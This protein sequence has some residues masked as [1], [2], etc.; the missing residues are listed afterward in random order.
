MLENALDVTG[1]E[2][3]TEDEESLLQGRVPESLK[4][5][6]THLNS[7]GYYTVGVAVYEKGIE[8]GYW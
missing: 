7:Y 4:Y 8:L 6:Y 1:L 3:D 5:D 2:P